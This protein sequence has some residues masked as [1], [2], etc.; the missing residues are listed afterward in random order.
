MAA[1]LKDP[2]QVNAHPQALPALP[3]QTL[4]A[5]VRGACSRACGPGPGVQNREAVLGA[6]RFLKAV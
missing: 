1:V 5:R 3:Y 4:K 2:S 6:A